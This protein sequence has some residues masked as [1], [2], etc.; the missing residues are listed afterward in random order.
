MHF[1]VSTTVLTFFFCSH[2]YGADTHADLDDQCDRYWTTMSMVGIAYSRATSGITVQSA[3]F[4]DAL[5]MSGWLSR[6][7]DD[8]IGCR[9][10]SYHQLRRADADSVIDVVFDLHTVMVDCSSRFTLYAR[11]CCGARSTTSL[12]HAHASSSRR[13]NRLVDRCSSAT[14]TAMTAG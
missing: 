3:S 13:L 7:G 6:V 14:S 12:K 1:T 9:G 10:K 11:Q 5:F 4:A 8:C 2:I